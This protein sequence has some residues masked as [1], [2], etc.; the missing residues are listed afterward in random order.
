MNSLFVKVANTL[1]HGLLLMLL[2]LSLIPAGIVAVALALPFLPTLWLWNR[3][4]QNQNPQSLNS[5]HQNPN[6]Q[7]LLLNPNPQNPR[8]Q[9]N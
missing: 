9:R 3:L 8:S 6:S 2:A 4:T 5:Q 7:S 1:I